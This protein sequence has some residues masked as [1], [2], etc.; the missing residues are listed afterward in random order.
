MAYNAYDNDR[1]QPAYNMKIE[2][3]VYY[4]EGGAD[5][6]N[7]AAMPV[8]RLRAMREESAAA[9]QTIYDKLR[10]ASAEWEKQAGQTLLFDKA[11]EFVRTPAVEH[12]S[13]QWE[14]SPYNNDRQQ[15]SNAVYSMSY[16]VYERTRYDRQQEKTVPVA[17]EL[18]WGVYT[19]PPQNLTHTKIAGQ[20]KKVYSD[21]AD[22]EKYLAGRIKAYSHLF[23]EISPPI[24]QAYADNF[25]LNGQ[26]LPGYIIEGEEPKPPDHAADIDGDFI[27]QQRKERENV[28]D[29]LSIRIS[30]SAE[31]ENGERGVWLKLPTTAEQLHEAM[32]AINIT[33]NNPQDFLIE[34]FES[35]LDSL[36]RLPLES[37][38]SAGIDELNYLAA[39]LQ[40]RD[41]RQID[42]LTA[43]TEFMT[44]RYDVHG[45]VELTQNTGVYDFH[46]DIFS[47]T[48]LGEH[49]LE[50]SGL[51]QIPDEWAA[52][53]DVEV[54][55]QLAA[56]NEKGLFTEQGYIVPNGE[57]WQPITEI[58]QEHRVMSFPTAE[59]ERS[60]PSID[61][62]T[63]AVSVT[64]APVQPQP[65]NVIVLESE[66]PADKLKEITDKLENG[67][68]GIFESEQY[69]DYLKTLSKFHN[70]SLNNTILIIAIVRKYTRAKKLTQRMLN[71]LVDYIEVHH[72]EKIDGVH[73]QKLI[74][75]Y[76][77]VGTVEIPNVL[78]LPLPEVTIQTRKGVAVSYSQ[79]QQAVVNF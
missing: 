48:Q 75:H 51:I 1:L 49:T 2:R 15:M 78:P 46:P 52:A 30:N 67:I 37:V 33:A 18:S 25:R 58:P 44:G 27:S 73:A 72:A 34:D 47:N 8:E 70:Y 26:L 63:P 29:P 71:E 65:V 69:Q 23:T 35:V 61:Y 32:K 3:T 45:L 79:S 59:P 9:E 12:T 62:D 22:M 68:A 42:K 28:N 24:P 17:W 13:N 54:L 40:S 76:N 74:I 20:D 41:S 36:T 4:N 64:P 14:K 57:E 77:C 10:E 16:L 39:A 66:R 55:G 31:N 5:I 60:T 7:L 21:K 53:I 56:K 43:A 38:R 6:S 11:I 19:N 50:H